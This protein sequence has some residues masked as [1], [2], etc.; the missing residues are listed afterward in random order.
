MTSISSDEFTQLQ[1]QLIQLKADLYESK[2]RESR[3]LKVADA[4][5]EKFEAMA[6]T[7]AMAEEARDRAEGEAANSRSRGTSTAG[8]HTDSNVSS[9]IGASRLSNLMSTVKRNSQSIGQ[10]LTAAAST[11]VGSS[12]SHPAMELQSELMTLKAQHAREMQVMQEEMSEQT[13]ALKLNMAHLHKKSQDLEKQ[14]ATLMSHLSNLE[15]ERHSLAE[16]RERELKRRQARE[17]TRAQRIK[18]GLPPLMEEEEDEDIDAARVKW[19][20]I[21]ESLEAQLATAQSDLVKRDERIAEL[22]R[23]VSDEEK[24]FERILMKMSEK[25]QELMHLRDELHAQKSAV[26]S[27]PMMSP[28]PSSQNMASP[29]KSPSSLRNFF[30]KGKEVLSPNPAMTPSPVLSPAIQPPTTPAKLSAQFAAV[31]TQPEE[32][33]STSPDGI[34]AASDSGV[35]VSSVAAPTASPSTPSSP[36]HTS[37]PVPWSASQPLNEQITSLQAELSQLR[38]LNEHLIMS[39]QKK[40]T[41]LTRNQDDSERIMARLAEKEMQIMQL[42]ES[43]GSVE[44]LHR[45]LKKKDVLIQKL[46]K[47]LDAAGSATAAAVNAAQS[48][49]STAMELKAANEAIANMQSQYDQLKETLENT[50]D[51][52]FLAETQLIDKQKLLGEQ[53]DT[54][55]ELRASTDGHE[56]TIRSLMAAKDKS[57]KEMNEHVDYLERKCISEI[58]EWERKYDSDMAEA[59]DKWTSMQAQLVQARTVAEEARAEEISVRG[60]LLQLRSQHDALAESERTLST[61]CEKLTRE[62]SELKSNSSI[63]TKKRNQ[64]VMELKSALKAELL[65]AKDALARL[66]HAEDDLVTMK[67]MQQHKIAPTGSFALN[68]ESI[69]NEIT[70]GGQSSD[71]AAVRGGPLPHHTTSSMSN[72]HTPGGHAKGVEQEVAN[73][74]A[75][76]LA[77]LEND[78]FILTKKLRSLEEHNDLL[79]SDVMQ[80]KEMVRNLVRRIES[81]ALSSHDGE[82]LQQTKLVG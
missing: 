49:S 30:N 73:A 61:A 21:R 29:Q 14:N 74:L 56:S 22:T 20:T 6:S 41:L 60:E 9:S 34:I 38:T 58:T 70:D 5:K 82:G 33:P 3:A 24:N 10:A 36:S 40:D 31:A 35:T 71:S 7:L 17:A 23:K 59:A 68:G 55:R 12:T 37:E 51:M 66:K 81:G 8:E 80:K 57:E 42:R 44:E 63:E 11:T 2:E 77:Q 13:T 1:N 46:Q 78:K 15:E 4:A 27:S 28:P 32:S 26:K 25:D 72:L 19:N 64:L 53:A 50:K 67:V 47:Q 69:N 79:Q 62:L 52:L 43:Q 18:D 76:K 39:V 16:K 54:L 45:D 48:S 65:R 75:Q